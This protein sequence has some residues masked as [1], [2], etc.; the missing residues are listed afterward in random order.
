MRRILLGVTLVVAFS[1]ADC[2]AKI[3]TQ[4]PDRPFVQY[5]CAYQPST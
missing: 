1:F 4:T 2:A 5:V 3:C